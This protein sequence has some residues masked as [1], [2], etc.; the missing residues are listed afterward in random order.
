VRVPAS[1]RF[2]IFFATSLLLCAAEL[3]PTRQPLF[4][5]Y[6][7]DEWA[8]APDHASIKWDVHLLPAQLSVHQRLVQRIEIVVPGGE[9]AKRRGRGELVLLTRFEDSDGH[10]WRGGNRMNLA[11]V[12]PSVKSQELT[13]TV[14]AFVRPGDYRVSIALANS[15]TGEHNFLRRP[16]H[17][18]PLKGDP[19]PDSWAGLPPVE[20]IQMADAPDSWFLPSVHGLLK[21]PLRSRRPAP[22]LAANVY[23]EPAPYLVN[24]NAAPSRITNAA[25]VVPSGEPRVEAPKIELLVN[26]SPSER[27]GGSAGLLRRNMSAVIPALKV[28]SSIN[29]K[30]RPPEAAV[31]DLT[32]H[33]VTFETADASSLDWS[34]LGKVLSETNPGIID[35]KVLARQSS[36]REY[37]ADEIARRAGESGPPRWLIFLSGSYS[38][39]AQEETPLPQLAPDPNRHIVYIHFIPQF[40]PAGAPLTTGPGARIAPPHRMHGPPPGLE[41]IIPPAPGRGPGGRGGPEGIS[42]DDF[43]RILKLMGAQV[44]TVTNPEAFRKSLASL[45]DQISAD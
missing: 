43:E 36:M 39:T 30:V 23:P 18:A 41:S 32:R 2:A 27:S 20:I 31:M 37:F 1:S 16:L 38:F 9:L 24:A 45:L 11:A 33:R 22:S 14:A 8:A 25:Y 29:A 34:A 13:F 6:P 17:V 35:A 19:L 5:D 3:L 26:T 10:R 42:P 28:L 4:S 7:F 15:E 44:I 21:L 40:G 12:E